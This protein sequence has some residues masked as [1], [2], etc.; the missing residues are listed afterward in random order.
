[1]Q[2][3]PNV[4]TPSPTS[5][6][7]ATSSLRG[8]QLLNVN[9][10]SSASGIQGAQDLVEVPSHMFHEATLIQWPALCYNV[11]HRGSVQHVLEPP[12]VCV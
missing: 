6:E 4:P 12:V 7:A 5:R 2:S 11:F 8:N 1:M 9:V 10:G 3:H